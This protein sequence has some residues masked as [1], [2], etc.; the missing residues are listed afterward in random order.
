MMSRLLTAVVVAVKR[1]W[2]LAMVLAVT[3]QSLLDAD[4]GNSFRGPFQGTVCAYGDFNFDLYTDIVFIQN[5]S[6]PGISVVIAP[7]QEKESMGEFKKFAVKFTDKTK[8]KIS[9]CAV[10]DYNGDSF[11]DVLV[12]FA[13]DTDKY[14]SM[15]CYGNHIAPSEVKNC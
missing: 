7:K 4:P 5:E 10:A 6:P 13:D 14:T 3:V 1:C 9:N 2:L 11:P 8:S 15:V 12:T